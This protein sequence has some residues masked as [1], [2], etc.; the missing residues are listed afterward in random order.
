MAQRFDKQQILIIGGG[1]AGALAAVRLAGKAKDR[2]AVTLLEPRT[3][4]VQRLRLHQLAT[5]QKVRAYDLAALTGK[6][7]TNV[8]GKAVAIDPGRGRAAVAQDGRVTEIPFDQ[9]L[10]AVGSG[11]DL[12]SVPGL[13]ENAQALGDPAAAE[14]LWGALRELKEGSRVVVCG[15]GFTGIEA[16]TEI[17]CRR[18]ELRV[19]LLSAGRLGAKFS[20]RGREQLDLRLAKRGVE[21]IEGERV[22][23]VEPGRV[24]LEGGAELE[25]DLVVWCGGFAARPLVRDSGLPA[26]SRGLL[27]V[28][29]SLRSVGHANVFGAGDVASIPDLPNGAAYRMTCQAGM[30]SGAHAAD[31]VLAAIKGEEPK[32]FD[33]GYIHIPLSLGRGDGLIQ[34]VDRADRPKNKLLVGRSAALYKEIVTRS[35]APSIAWERRLPGLLRWPS[36]GKAPAVQAERVTGRASVEGADHD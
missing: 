36:G 20:E 1:Y 9:V 5:G 33:F 24:T 22:D 35:P 15:G 2:A 27:A 32:P 10:L 19:S 18:P 30:P 25:A 11:V 34:F 31:T 28:D 8:R 17:A 23:A 12:D 16:A 26:D 3:E 4:L 21:A 29:S 7:V 13:R 6:R 14:R